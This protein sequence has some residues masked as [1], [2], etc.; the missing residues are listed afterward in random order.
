MKL[1]NVRQSISI[2]FSRFGRASS[3]CRN[4]RSQVKL[5]EFSSMRLAHSHPSS[6]DLSSKIF[7]LRVKR[8]VRVVPA[9]SIALWRRLYRVARVDAD[10]SVCGVRVWVNTY[11]YMYIC[12]VFGLI[13]VPFIV[14]LGGKRSCIW[15]FRQHANIFIKTCYLNERQN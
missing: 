8:D 15:L 4:Y 11:V 2:G 1:L 7:Q 13:D 3:V 5:I 12:C 9:Y 14:P 10:K 6:V